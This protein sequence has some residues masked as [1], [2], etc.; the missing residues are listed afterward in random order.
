[1]DLQFLWWFFYML[2][3]NFWKFFEKIK[4]K[5]NKM[6]SSFFSTILLIKFQV[7]SHLWSHSINTP[8]RTHFARTIP[9]GFAPLSHLDYRT[10]VCYRTFA[11]TH[12]NT[13]IN[14]HFKVLLAI[15]VIKGPTSKVAFKIEI[16]TSSF[17]AKRQNILLLDFHLQI[18][19]ST[20]RLTAQAKFFH[21]YGKKSGVENSLH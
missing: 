2:R 20:C 7:R 1:M 16:N 17:D 13:L 4:S 3:N 9:R 15:L 6:F 8:T 19:N 11:R 5:A 18:Q 21:Q 14:S 12:S 10:H